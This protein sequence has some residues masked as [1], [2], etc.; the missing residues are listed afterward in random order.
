VNTLLL[1]V[2]AAGAAS[3]VGGVAGWRIR[4]FI[5]VRSPSNKVRIA[6]ARTDLELRDIG[7]RRRELDLR[8]DIMATQAEGIVRHLSTANGEAILADDDL[9]LL[10]RTVRGRRGLTQKALAG[11]CWQTAVDGTVEARH[12]L[13][14]NSGPKRISEIEHGDSPTVDE[15]RV[16]ATALGLRYVPPGL[17][18]PEASAPVLA[19][20][21]VTSPE[22]GEGIVSLFAVPPVL[23]GDGRSPRQPAPDILYDDD[24]VDPIQ[25]EDRR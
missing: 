20:P 6:D 16:L 18:D 2:P 13:G 14:G 24:G 15:L 3:V 7:L 11:L 8:E 22:P 21:Q 17:R 1:L 12:R 4:G 25:A 19:I 5:P 23:L 9:T 10:L